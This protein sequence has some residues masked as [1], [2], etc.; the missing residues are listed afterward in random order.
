MASGVTWHEGETLGL[1]QIAPIDNSDPGIEAL[2]GVLTQTG[3]LFFDVK[4]RATAD[5]DGGDILPVESRKGF[6]IGDVIE[7]RDDG[8][9]R[10]QGTILTIPSETELGLAAPLGA[11]ISAGARVIKKAITGSVAGAIY[12]TTPSLD[13][14]TWGYVVF[15]D[16][17]TPELFRRQKLIAELVLDD[18]G[19]VHHEQSVDITFGE[20]ERPDVT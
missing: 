13:T 4:T 8:K 12:G 20:I 11:T 19:G 5:Q 7:V 14:T 2:P 1:T 3:F 18:G 10:R 15:F 17:T 6:V 16:Y 9:L